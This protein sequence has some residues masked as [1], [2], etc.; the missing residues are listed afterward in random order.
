M[1]DPVVWSSGLRGDAH[2][3]HYHR[4]ISPIRNGKRM[5]AASKRSPSFF[6]DATFGNLS[7]LTR[8][9]YSL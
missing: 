7:D 6:L 2:L 9:T 5:P 4:P 8:V 1:H 3:K